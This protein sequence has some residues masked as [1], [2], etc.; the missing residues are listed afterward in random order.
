MHFVSKNMS[1]VNVKVVAR[2]R[3]QNKIET[4]RGGKPCVN[5]QRDGKE[6]FL[7]TDDQ[8]EFRFTFD[9]VFGPTSKQKD[10]FEY[11]GRPVIDGIF[12]GYNGT[13][14]AYGQ[15]S[16]GKT[17]TMSG[18]DGSI[19]NMELQGVIPRCINYIFEKFG[20]ADE[21]I[22]F[23]VQT[24]FMEI[25]LERVKDLLNIEKS[26]LPIRE[27]PGRGIY[28]DGVTEEYV[29]SPDECLQ[30]IQE[31]SEN[32]VVAA[33]GMNAG[34]SRS[35]SVTIIKLSATDTKTGTKKRGKLCLVDLAGSE[36]VRKTGAKGQQL[37]EAKMINKSLSALGNVI[38]ALTAGKTKHIPYRD[39]KL[40]RLLQESLGGNACTVMIICCSPSSYN[41]PETV[42]TLRF[43]NRAKSIKNIA[44]V[45]QQRSVEELT[46]LLMRAEKAIDVQGKYIA[47]LEAKVKNSSGANPTSTT[48]VEANETDQGE[49]ENLQDAPKTR[50]RRGSFTAENLELESQINDL[51]LQVAQYKKELEEEREETKNLSLIVEEKGRRLAEVEHELKSEVENAQA[52]IDLKAHEFHSEIE[53]L[54]NEL[55]LERDNTK[56]LAQVVEEREVRM[57]ELENQGKQHVQDKEDLE[58]T[59]SELNIITE[60]NVSLRK[61]LESMATQVAAAE[62][63]LAAM[64]LAAK[65]EVRKGEETRDSEKTTKST[66]TSDLQRLVD[67]GSL[68]MEEAVEMQSG[69]AA[70]DNEA[71]ENRIKDADNATLVSEITEQNMKLNRTIDALRN[72]LQNRCQK[73][74]ELELALD[75]EKDKL[76]MVENSANETVAQQKQRR[77]L[78]QRLE[79]LVM[80]HRQLLR[81]YATME[82]EREKARK[83]DQLKANRIKQL[84]VNAR[85]LAKNM[86][87]QSERHEKDM[88]TTLT[89]KDHEINILR[90]KLNQFLAHSEN[91]GQSPKSKG[92]KIIGGKGGTHTIRGKGHHTA[93]PAHVRTSSTSSGSSSPWATNVLNFFKIGQK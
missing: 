56:S 70:N 54:Q 10:V 17:H 37:E 60:Q 23:T 5:V 69:N 34:S 76:K 53:R 89:A 47:Q 27:E 93:S 33:T 46:K 38:N 40:T 66:L 13:I 49:R 85:Q 91:G 92:G 6:V 73:V 63:N 22:E 19:A 18:A 31:A 12:K 74:I 36:M 14:F 16:S 77:A 59:R 61:K 52:K 79:Q 64:P 26:N 55:D 82:L 83:A 86:L 1:T 84:E 41:A 65:N 32:R 7:S 24:S 28:V 3:P 29:T 21:H 30:K 48:P 9:K 72:D 45:N 44:R 57:A 75:K 8:G 87:S 51:N 90:N 67:E 81:K 88:K 20:E 11:I 39:S 25:Y 15:T 35:H 42:S 58:K 43:G 68:T 71:N 80:V 62:A 4:S 50:Q 2:I 78:Q